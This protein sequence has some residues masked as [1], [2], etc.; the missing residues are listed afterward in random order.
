VEPREENTITPPIETEAKENKSSAFHQQTITLLSPR[1][2][3]I[4]FCMTGQSE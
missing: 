2:Y 1:H 3:Y 4:I